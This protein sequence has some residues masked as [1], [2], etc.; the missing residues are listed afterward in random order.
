MKYEFYLPEYENEADYRM[1]RVS[2]LTLIEEK[3]VQ[4]VEKHTK[5]ILILFSRLIKKHAGVMVIKDGD[6]IGEG[7]WGFGDNA[8]FIFSS[9]N[10]DF[11]KEEGEIVLARIKKALYGINKDDRE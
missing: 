4:D 6:L 5:K 1:M 7:Y 2:S 3:D 11:N 8:D 9:I 10:D